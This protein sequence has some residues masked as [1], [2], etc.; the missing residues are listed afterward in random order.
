MSVTPSIKSWAI[1]AAVFA[2]A[3]W[4]LDIPI[5][6]L[7]VIAVGYVMILVVIDRI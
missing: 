3:A 7:P 6:V 4:A 1:I 5:W 2:F